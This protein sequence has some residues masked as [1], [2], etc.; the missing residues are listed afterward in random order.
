MMGLAG[1]YQ[2]HSLTS[3]HMGC[4]QGSLHLGHSLFSTAGSLGLG[5]NLTPSLELYGRAIIPLTDRH[6]MGTDGC[7]TYHM[8]CAKMYAD[9]RRRHKW[10][11]IQRNTKGLPRL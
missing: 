2:G 1:L 9:T 11:S 6:Q 8:G 4:S 10:A 3:T 7:L 5:F